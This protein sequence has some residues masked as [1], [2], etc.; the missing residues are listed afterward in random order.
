MDSRIRFCGNCGRDVVV[1]PGHILDKF[2]GRVV[3]EAFCPNGHSF[4]PTV[5]GLSVIVEDDVEAFM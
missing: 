3:K 1:V 2:D 4:S 5:I